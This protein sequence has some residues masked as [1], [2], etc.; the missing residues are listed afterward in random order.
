M[1]DIQVRPSTKSHDQRFRPSARTHVRARD[2]EHWPMQAGDRLRA[3]VKRGTSL[4]NGSNKQP[5]T[6]SS[7]VRRPTAIEQFFAPFSLER[8]F[9]LLGFIVAVSVISFFSLDVACG[10]PFRRASLLFDATSTICGAVLLVLCWHVF[11][12]QVKGF[13]R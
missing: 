7:D 13:T 5:L 3:L 8:S 12:E 1:H 4:S 9:T 2:N 10:W 6:F 11:W